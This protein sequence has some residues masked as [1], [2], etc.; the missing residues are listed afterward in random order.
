MCY[1]K[2][3][4]VKMYKKERK[5]MRKKEK[6]K[7]KLEQELG[8]PESGK[9]VQVIF[10]TPGGYKIAD[11]YERI[12]YGDRGPYIEFSPEQIA[13]ENFRCTRR[14]I[15]YFDKWYSPDGVMLYYQ[16]RTVKYADYLIGKVYVDPYIVKVSMADV[17]TLV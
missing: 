8:L 14:G 6:D 13:W 5:I 15:G 7:E 11:G 10:T 3:Q 1:I 17:V 9:E 4:M 2:R 16:R 12:V